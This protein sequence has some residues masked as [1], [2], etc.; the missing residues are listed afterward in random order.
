MTECQPER[1][2]YAA[3]V[4][5]AFS[6]G[7]AGSIVGES[8][9]VRFGTFDGFS[10]L[11]S[12]A[13]EKPPGHGWQPPAA[14]RRSWR[15]G[16]KGN[17]EY[18]KPGAA[19]KLKKKRAA[20]RDEEPNAGITIASMLDEWV[21]DGEKYRDEIE[22]AEKPGGGREPHFSLTFPTDELWKHREYTWTRE[23]ARE[24]SAPESEN[25]DIFRESPDRS[26]PGPEKWDR[27]KAHME[28][29]GWDKREPLIVYFGKNDVAKVGEGNHRLA[30]ARE[31]GMKAIPVKLVYWQDV[32]LN[33]AQARPPGSGWIPPAAGRKSWRRGVKGHYEYWTPGTGVTKKRSKDKPKKTAKKQSSVMMALSAAF[34][35][36]TE[37]SELADDPRAHGLSSAEAAKYVALRDHWEKPKTLLLPDDPAVAAEMAETLMALSNSYDAWSE[38]ARKRKD[39]G[40]AAHDRRSSSS[41]GMLQQRLV[42]EA[43][44]RGGEY[45]RGFL[46]V[47]HPPSLLDLRPEPVPPKPE[48][49]PEPEGTG[50]QMH[51]GSGREL[52]TDIHD[53]HAKHTGE[54]KKLADLSPGKRP[55]RATSAARKLHGKLT[56]RSDAGDHGPHEKWDTRA[57]TLKEFV[58]G[59]WKAGATS[60]HVEHESGWRVKV[61][62]SERG[63][64]K[65]KK[66]RKSDVVAKPSIKLA[67][68]YMK[69]HANK[70]YHH[71]INEMPDELESMTPAEK[72][73][74]RE[75]AQNILSD[76]D[77]PSEAKS[78]IRL[79]SRRVGKSLDG[80]GLLAKASRM[81]EALCG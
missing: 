1:L 79:L 32:R 66:K 14:G 20:W 78:Q 35:F 43:R 21:Q 13:R 65:P 63:E 60:V 30:I 3:V 16:T 39:H 61:W 58:G 62:S 2:T 31:M 67:K 7:D 26:Y 29:N 42:N 41:L 75:L 24:G 34:V 19:P 38:Y 76:E 50:G 57:G 25:I 40:T 53:T 5:K 28:K 36:D 46:A 10:A 8:V 73:M 48:D 44:A 9:S 70:K 54:F 74:V 68:V 51:H 22:W 49:E 11:V 45:E 59:A 6:G 18:W 17:Y 81:L 27:L 37:I 72:L 77:A 23:G 47:W 56:L 33:K 52:F 55:Q 64:A 12:K 71:I 4:L 15:R 69:K 80:F